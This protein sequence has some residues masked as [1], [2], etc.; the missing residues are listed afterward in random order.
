MPDYGRP[1]RFGAFPTPEAGALDEVL[2]LARV[3]DLGLRLYE[4]PCSAA[5]SECA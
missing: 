4:T 2:G 1:L 5:D 3:A